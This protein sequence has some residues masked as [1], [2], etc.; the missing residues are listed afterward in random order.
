MPTTIYQTMPRSDIESGNPIS[1]S[2]NL[3]GILNCFMHMKGFNG[4]EVTLGS[5]ICGLRLMKDDTF[6]NRHSHQYI[7]DLVCFISDFGLLN[8]DFI[9][10]H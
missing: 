5:H 7:N 1:Q 9:F 6:S 2:N 10:I 8:P 3:L 4:L